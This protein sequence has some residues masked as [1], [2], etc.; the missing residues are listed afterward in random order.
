MARDLFNSVVN[1][2]SYNYLEKIKPINVFSNIL[3]PS[4]H[5]P[6]LLNG[7]YPTLHNDVNLAGV[8]RDGGGRRQ[9]GRSPNDR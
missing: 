8:Q 2:W 1:K 9:S 4:Y 3:N 5:Q 7:Y 6:W